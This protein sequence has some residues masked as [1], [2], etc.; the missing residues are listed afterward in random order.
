MLFFP[1]RKTCVLL[2]DLPLFQIHGSTGRYS[3]PSTL[4]TIP[5]SLI[6][7]VF[8][9]L[10][11]SHGKVCTSLFMPEYNYSNTHVLICPIIENI[12]HTDFF[13]FGHFVNFQVSF[14]CKIIHDI[15]NEIYIRGFV[16][17][18]ICFLIDR[19]HTTGTRNTYMINVL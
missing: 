12:A 11:C 9:R 14:H 13:V 17:V 10:L 16:Y 3:K 1:M 5:P 15:L 6:V 8:W 2:H 7:V 4:W 18:K 19:N